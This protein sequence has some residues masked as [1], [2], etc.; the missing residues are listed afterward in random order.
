MTVDRDR[1][2]SEPTRE[3][4]GVPMRRKGLEWRSKKYAP[5]QNVSVGNWYMDAEDFHQTHKTRA[6]D[7][8]PAAKPAHDKQPREH[9]GT[10]G[11]NPAERIHP[12]HRRSR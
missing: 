12:L 9:D 10:N 11:S 8:S 6:T 1:D 7:K 4:E 3:M 5:V 2:R